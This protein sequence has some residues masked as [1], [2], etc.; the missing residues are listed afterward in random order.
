MASLGKDRSS[1]H[2][3]RSIASAEE[4]SR[5]SILC[6]K[7]LSFASRA[8]ICSL[9]ACSPLGKTTP[10]GAR[11]AGRSRRQTKPYA[12]YDPYAPYA[13]YALW[14]P[15]AMIAPPRSD[16][17]HRNPLLNGIAHRGHR[18][19]RGSLLSRARRAAVDARHRQDV[20]YVGSTA[21]W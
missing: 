1:R 18:Q 7:R 12:P 2:S 3:S 5:H 13:P 4:A 21:A 6:A 8:G 19:R 14:G 9:E 15:A 11:M 20:L 17:H 10:L 16:S